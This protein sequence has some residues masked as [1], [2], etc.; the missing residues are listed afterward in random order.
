M[1]TFDISEIDEVIT[2]WYFSNDSEMDRLGL[3]FVEVTKDE[4]EGTFDFIFNRNGKQWHLKFE[5]QSYYF[6]CKNE[7]HQEA[8]EKCNEVCAQLDEEEGVTQEEPRVGV[9]KILN[10]ALVE[11][12]SNIKKEVKGDEE[13]FMEVD[14]LSDQ[15][16]E[17]HMPGWS[18]DDEY[19]VED[20][21]MDKKT[22]SINDQITKY[23]ISLATKDSIKLFQKMKPV[24]E[25][26][27]VKELIDKYMEGLPDV[28][29]VQI[30]EPLL[31]F[32]LTIDLNFMSVEP[33]IYKS[34]G[35]EMEELVEYLFI[36]ED[37]KLLMFLDDKSIV[38]KD[39]AEL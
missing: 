13:E 37:N 9:V 10:L 36:F 12:L 17:E 32:K 24:K 18:D 31:M 35:F 33:H 11:T 26:F 21:P 39:I 14:G 25:A 4:E 6:E 22:S 7:G 15:A 38:D 1:E 30:F 27:H 16:E 2:E 20:I 19:D 29:Q 5:F 28:F 23:N 3:E 34:L 8:V